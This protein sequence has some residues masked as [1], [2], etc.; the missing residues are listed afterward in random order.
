MSGI[1]DT[2]IFD[3]NIF[4]TQIGISIMTS[5]SINRHKHGE[6]TTFGN[7]SSSGNTLVVA[8]AGAGI[9]IRVLSIV[10]INGATSNSV[11]FQSGTTDITCLFAYAGNGGMVLD[12][13]KAGHFQTAANEALNINLSGA[14]AVGY[15]LNY[16]LTQV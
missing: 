8:A 3:L 1:F 5:A 15:Q 10:V 4:D 6:V 11:K 16:Q 13:N 14:S 9:M 12:H 7:P 2:G